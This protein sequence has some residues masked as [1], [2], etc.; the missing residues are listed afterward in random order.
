MDTPSREI[1]DTTAAFEFADN[2]VE[3][4]FDEHEDAAC[5]KEHHAPEADDDAADAIDEGGRAPNENEPFSDIMLRL[6]E[7]NRLGT[8]FACQRARFP[9]Y[10]TS[11]KPE[12]YLVLFGLIW[13]Y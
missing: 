7:K 8:W 9:L 13:S 12:S 1:E 3:E 11:N 5:D 2:D 6:L 4:P 10:I